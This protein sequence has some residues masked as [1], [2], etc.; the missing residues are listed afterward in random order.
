MWDSAKDRAN[1]ASMAWPTR[2]QTRRW[3]FYQCVDPRQQLGVTEGQIL[4]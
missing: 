3:R 4:A 2:M 1:G